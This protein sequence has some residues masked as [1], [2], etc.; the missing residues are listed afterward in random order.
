MEFLKKIKN[1]IIFSLF[2]KKIKDLKV[3]AHFLIKRKGE[4]IQFV[5]GLKKAWHAGESVWRNKKNLGLI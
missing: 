2:F 4:L 1:L 3:S 5:S